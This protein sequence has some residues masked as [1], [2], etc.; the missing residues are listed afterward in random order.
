M[1][2]IDAHHHFW[3]YTAEEFGWIDDSM[4]AIRRDFLPADLKS[5]MDAA[6]VD[7]VISVEAR[8][9][10]G[11]TGFLLEHAR[12]NPWVYGV[13]GKAP[14]SQG[15][16]AV[17]EYL[18][19]TLPGADKLVGVRD[20]LQGSPIEVFSDATFNDGLSALAP[21]NLVFDLCIYHNQMQ[22]TIELVD[23]HPEQRF[24]L[25]HIGKPNIKDNVLEP[26]ATQFRSLAERDNVF[27][28]L[29]GMVTEADPTNWTA[30]QLQPYFDTALDAFG[31]KRLMF[32]SDWP[33]CLVGVEY[34]DWLSTVKTL[35]DGLSE[36]EQADFYGNT[37]LKAYRIDAD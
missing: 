22:A 25:D 35:A 13:V 4:S 8:S 1:R 27:C 14:L 23:R 10:L 24:V 37:V 29:S 5:A 3:K 17:E 7:G 28:K 21:H 2:I 12:Q 32:G 26:W 16:S 36:S 33:V 30:E 6:G 19:K 11:E 15:K 31:P 9:I 34:P 20:V 18:A